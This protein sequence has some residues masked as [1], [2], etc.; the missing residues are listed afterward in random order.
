M[1]FE[2]RSG[3]F[4]LQRPA[5]ARRWC[6]RPIWRLPIRA[7]N[8]INESRYFLGLKVPFSTLFTLNASAA[9][10]DCS[11]FRPSFRALSSGPVRYFLVSC[12]H[13]D[14]FY[15]RSRDGHGRRPRPFGEATERFGSHG[16][17]ILQKQVPGLP[18]GQHGSGAYCAFLDS[19]QVSS[20]S[21]T[22]GSVS[23]LSPLG[24][25]RR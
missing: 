16:P 20:C 14:G 6:I 23:L 9:T 18:I 11:Q 5:G 12:F 19:I 4:K 25:E 3:P 8:D 22:V 10:K 17:R 24:P 1:P 7:A 15:P 21:F 13:V 2:Y